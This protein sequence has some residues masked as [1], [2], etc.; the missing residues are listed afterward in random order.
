MNNQRL[1][2]SDESTG[3]SVTNR[4]GLHVGESAVRE[5]TSEIWLPEPFEPRY[6]Y[7]L[8]VWL[9]DDGGNVLDDERIANRAASQN[10]IVLS[11]R[12]PR[13]VDDGFGWP[14]E[15]RCGVGLDIWRLVAEELAEL[16]PELRFHSERVF[17]AGRGTGAAAAWR[18]WLGHS[19]QIA[20]AALLDPPSAVDASS[21]RSVAVGT[22]QKPGLSGRLWIGGKNAQKWRSAAKSAYALGAEVSLAGS[23]RTDEAVGESLDRWVMKA[24]PTAVFA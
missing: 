23:V 24:L 22:T 6:A 12:G 3:L 21:L 4:L 16:P 5:W 20:G 15:S 17:L 14:T 18:A 2:F 11:V 9:H 8:L 1:I 7:P 10:M 13:S 19:D